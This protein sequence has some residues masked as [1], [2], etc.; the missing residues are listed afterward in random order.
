I[1]YKQFGGYELF[2]EDNKQFSEVC[3][4]NRK[5]INAFLKPIFKKDAFTLVENPF[6]FKNIDNRL[7]FCPFEGQIDTGKMMNAL[8]KMANK[9]NI[10]IL[11]NTSLNKFV[12]NKKDVS[13]LL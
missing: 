1:S 6:H 5:R 10:F 12:D 7:L 3:F 11:N 9:K 13:L 8:L 2:T 4:S